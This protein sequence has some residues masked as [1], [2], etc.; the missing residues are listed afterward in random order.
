V[1][2]AVYTETGDPADVLRVAEVAETR[3]ELG[4]RALHQLLLLEAE[5][6]ER[7]L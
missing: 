2:A 7:A 3:H 1:R 4:A 5:L 6:V